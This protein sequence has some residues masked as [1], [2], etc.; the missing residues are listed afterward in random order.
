[1]PRIA[2]PGCAAIQLKYGVRSSVSAWREWV[3]AVVRGTAGFHE[4][5]L[6][7]AGFDPR[8][9]LQIPPFYD[10]NY[11]EPTVQLALR[12]LCRPGM[13]CFDV[14]ANAGALSLVMS[15]LVGPRGVVC[16]FEASRRIVDKTHWNLVQAGC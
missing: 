7:Q 13:V 3:K 9:T 5:V 14:G 10:W 16:A 6:T 8:T 11:W 4:R 2:L 12:D 15:R 1:M